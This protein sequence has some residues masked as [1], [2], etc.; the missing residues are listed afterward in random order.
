[1]ASHKAQTPAEI[2]QAATTVRVPKYSPE[3]VTR[4]PFV[5]KNNEE[6]SQYVH[7]SE[8]RPFF[9]HKVCEDN[10]P[11]ALWR[12]QGLKIFRASIFSDC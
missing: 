4:A 8:F 12:R 3:N 11:P 9:H 2:A 5:F 7:N 6:L 10:N 1:M